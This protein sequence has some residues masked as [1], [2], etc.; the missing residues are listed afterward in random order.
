MHPSECAIIV[1]YEVE[2]MILG[3]TGEAMHGERKQCQK[4]YEPFEVFSII[5]I[6]TWLRIHLGKALSNS[7]NIPQLAQTIV[8]KCN[9]CLASMLIY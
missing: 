1:Y 8:D 2:A 4:V 7:T 5:M 3:D 9:V 6:L